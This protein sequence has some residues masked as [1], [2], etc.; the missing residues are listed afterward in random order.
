MGGHKPTPSE[1]A[2]P[3]G[4]P[5]DFVTPSEFVML[6]SRGRYPEG[7]PLHGEESIEIKYMTAKEEDILTSPSLLSK[8]IALDRLISSVVLDKSINTASLLPC[9]RN[10]V[11]IAARITGF[12]PDY[13]S[14]Y[15]CPLC[16]AEGE[17]TF[18]LN[19]HEIV[20]AT[21]E[22]LAENGIESR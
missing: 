21:P 13:E 5:M 9:D 4:N 2:P 14:G 17:A 3:M 16:G 20:S 19:D 8:G 12:G 15:V 10:A 1:D 18:D 7:H 6:P 22:E 11:L